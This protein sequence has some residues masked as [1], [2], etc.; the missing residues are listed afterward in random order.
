M[1]KQGVF[2]LNMLVRLG[3]KILPLI[4][5]KMLDTRW[6]TMRQMVALLGA[7]A[8]PEYPPMRPPRPRGRARQNEALKSFALIY[9]QIRGIAAFGPE[10]KNSDKASWGRP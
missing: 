2:F 6:F 9:S 1:G 10:G 8:T 5:A 7:M 3:E 4:E